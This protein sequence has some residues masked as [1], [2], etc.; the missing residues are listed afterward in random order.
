MEKSRYRLLPGEGV[1]AL[2]EVQDSVAALIDSSGI[3]DLFPSQKEIDVW[4]GKPI[5]EGSTLAEAHKIWKPG[6]FDRID[7]I[8]GFPFRQTGES[9]PGGLTRVSI[10]FIQ[11]RTP[12]MGSFFG[13]E[14][15]F[16]SLLANLSELSIWDARGESA[17]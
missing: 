15:Y 1:F 12:G 13:Y 17:S 9:C 4:I 7:S 10:N 5:E 16:I 14:G 2:P 3:L 6:A 11:K 8:P